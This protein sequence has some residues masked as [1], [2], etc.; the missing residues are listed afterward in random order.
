[1]DAIGVCVEVQEP[2][3]K[4]DNLRHEISCA[5]DLCDDLIHCAEHPQRLGRFSRLVNSRPICEHVFAWSYVSTY[6]ASSW[7]SPQA[8]RVRS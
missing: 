5:I 3:G 1:V 7:P 2:A 4:L 8:A 6:L